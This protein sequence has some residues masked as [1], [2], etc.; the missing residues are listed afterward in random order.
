MTKEDQDLILE[1]CQREVIHSLLLAISFDHVPDRKPVITA[2]LLYILI[3][4][5]QDHFVLVICQKGVSLDN[6]IK[7]L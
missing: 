3:D 2:L 1:H 4:I 7:G 5:L 6:L